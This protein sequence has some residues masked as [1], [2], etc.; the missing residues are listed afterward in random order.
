MPLACWSCSDIAAQLVTLGIV[1]SI[2]TSTVW[3]W[4]KTERLQGY[5]TL[6]DNPLQHR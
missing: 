5:L 4:L 2:A 1:V 3:R 6:L